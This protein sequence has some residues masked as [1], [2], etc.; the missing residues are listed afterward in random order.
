MCSVANVQTVQF[1]SSWSVWSDILSSCCLWNL[2][3]MKCFPAFSRRS[4]RSQR[5]RSM[6]LFP[7]ASSL[8]SMFTLNHRTSECNVQVITQGQWHKHSL[9]G[10]FLS[11]C[12]LD[13]YLL[14]NWCKRFA[15]MSWSRVC[16]CVCA[17][18]L[19]VILCHCA[20]HIVSPS[21]IPHLCF[22]VF[23]F[24]SKQKCFPC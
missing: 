21:V 9:Q 12:K 19:Y 22:S 6:A 24:P 4:P 15:F 23:I 14:P 13:F 7:N 3:L 10:A 2:W 20:A 16:V 17:V 1:P 18:Y 11:R 5:T 8:I